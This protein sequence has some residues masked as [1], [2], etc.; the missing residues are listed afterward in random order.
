MPIAMTTTSDCIVTEPTFEHHL[1]DGWARRTLIDDVRRGLSRHP[2]R[3]P[4][5]WLYD[6]RGS[7]LFD[8]ITRL[9]EYYPTEAE[10]SVLEREAGS[11]ASLTGAD[12]LIEL[13]SGTSDKTHTL[14]RALRATGQLRTFVPFDVSEQT[15]RDSAASLTSRYPGLQV[16]GIVG[17]FTL[18]L[19]Q[20]PTEG[21]PLVAFLGSTIG[22]LYTEERH[23]FLAMLAEHLPEGAFVLLGVDLVKS[24][25][26][27][28]RAYDD[29]HGV[30][31]EFSRNVLHVL[32]RELGAD[33]DVD[34]FDHIAL[35]DPR[36]ERMDL[37][38]RVNGDLQVRI[39]DADVQLELLDGEE[40]RVEISTKFRIPQI[41]TEVTEA[42][43]DV[44]Q[45][46]TDRPGDVALV[47]ASIPESRT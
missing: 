45:I 25:E 15:L 16:H 29:P 34:A 23:A 10:R 27:L 41:A 7:Q 42:G 43:F 40:I 33:F 21:T 4:P 22:N 19:A 3:L 6:D 1:D 38:L 39:N 24:I 37:R 12:T 28:V 31:A 17:D 5:R 47:L 44:R 11:I 26:R 8:Q 13:G 36:Q 32:N 46:W 20:L 9:A 14:I 2:L 30:T 35:W 18:H